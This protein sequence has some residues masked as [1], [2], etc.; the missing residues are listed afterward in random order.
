MISYCEK[1]KQVLR[2]W[3]SQEHWV[4]FRYLF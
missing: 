2:N 3:I 1:L 4:T